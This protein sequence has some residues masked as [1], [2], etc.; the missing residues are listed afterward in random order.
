MSRARRALL[1][2]SLA[3]SAVAAH[4][5]TSFGDFMT[6]SG[7]GTLGVVHS[8][9]D[10][11]D[12]VA[13]IEQPVGVGYSHSWSAT[14]DSDLGVQANLQFTDALSGVVQVLSRD[15]ESGNF[16]PGIEWANLKYDFTPD[17]SLRVG[18]MLLPTY[19]VSDI[20]N[21]GYS[22]PWVRVPVEITYASN[23]SHSDGMDVIYRVHSG[24]VSQ[25]FELQLGVTNQDLPGEL[26]T[27]ARSRLAL[28]G[29]TLRYQDLT[30]HLIYQ[31]CDPINLPMIREHLVALGAI[32]DPGRYFVS[33]DSNYTHDPYFGELLSWYLSAGVR[34][35]R[36]TPYALFADMHAMAEGSS[37]LPALGNQ[38]T[39]GGGVRWDFVKNMD[40]KVQLERATLAS[41]D[42][43][44]AFTNLQPGAKAGDSA[45]VLSVAV[46]FVF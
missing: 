42:D 21:V 32:Y 43:T 30:V 7:F 20:R 24:D 26:Y 1:G 46:D 19:E 11:G 31:E 27:S 25:D 15:D 23:A 17:L 40:L 36:F 13:T 8:N 12:F 10:Q 5:E 45:A 44:V 6:V 9:Y 4:A 39:L 37:Q 2:A 14:P 35:G 22:L 38:H 29:D 33:A 3:L 34:L 28:L 16:K 41:L 18:R